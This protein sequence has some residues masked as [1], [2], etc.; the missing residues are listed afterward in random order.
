MARDEAL[1][2]EGKSPDF[3]FTF[4]AYTWSRPCVTYGYLQKPGEMLD[5]AALERL[6]APIVRRPTGGKVA[7][8]G[9]D[10]AYS[11]TAHVGN[12]S[13]RCLVLDWV[14][15]LARELR[16]LGFD[17]EA[18]AERARDEWRQPLCA[19]E[20][21]PADILLNGCKLAGHGFRKA[22][23]ALQLQGTMALRPPGERELA[24]LAAFPSGALEPSGL[25]ALPDTAP[26]AEE[27]ARRFAAALAA[28]GDA[29][30]RL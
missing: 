15:V 8:H 14:E 7:L 16:E 29:L 12:R 4:H 3:P 27:L 20:R 10:L 26:P 19:A 24:L 13:V 2:V 1:L 22:G 25:A 23:P 30:A 28:G 5:L 21:G 18:G 17:V 9:H 6:D 11:I